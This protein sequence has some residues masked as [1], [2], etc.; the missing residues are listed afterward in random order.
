VPFSLPSIADSL[1]MG[2][3]QASW[4]PRV[5]LVASAWA[6]F[7]ALAPAEVSGQAASGKK[8]TVVSDDN[9]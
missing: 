5:A 2:R 9:K 8:A 1:R 6:L 4:L 7:M 3:R